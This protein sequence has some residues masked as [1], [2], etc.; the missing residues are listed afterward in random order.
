MSPAIVPFPP[1]HPALAGALAARDYSVPTPVQVAVLEAS[2]GPNDLLV[3][4]RTGSGKTVAFGLAMARTL[5]GEAERF[6]SQSRQPL[7][8]IIAPT[9][10]LAL[11]VQRELAWLYAGTDARIATCVGG[12][13]PRVE[14][15]DLGA[16]AHIVVGTPGRLRDHLERKRLDLGSLRTVVLDEAD[17]M[18]DLGF[19]EDLTFILDATPDTRQTLLFS[20]TIPRAI[21]SLA[22]R[23]QTNAV[24]IETAGGEEQHTDIEYHAVRVGAGDTEK[25]VANVLRFHEARAAL[26]F[27][28]TREGVKRMHARLLERGFSAVALSGELTQ[29]ERT[30]A[31]QALR[32]GRARVLVA[33][34]VAARGLDLPDLTLVIH[35][36]LPNDPETLLHRSGRTGRAGRKGICMLVVPASRQRKAETL[37]YAAK[38]RVRWG[39]PPA[40]DEIRERD[41]ERFLADPVFTEDATEAELAEVAAL[42]AARTSDQIALA[43]VRLNRQK[44]PATETI[45]ASTSSSRRTDRPAVNRPRSDQ[46]RPERPVFRVMP[47]S[48]TAEPQVRAPRPPRPSNRDMT[49]FRLNIGRA[50]DADPRW[51]LPLICRAGGVTKTEIGAIKIFDNETRFEIVSEVADAFADAARTAKKKEGHISRVSASAPEDEA[52][53]GAAIAAMPPRAPHVPRTKNQGRHTSLPLAERLA[54]AAAAERPRERWK[55]KKPARPASDVSSTETGGNDR[56]ASGATRPVDHAARPGKPQ[57]PPFKPGGKGKFFPKKK[58]RTAAASTG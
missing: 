55:D 35:A 40:A 19:R 49:W 43:L 54:A 32:D 11:Q 7:A 56:S 3:S 29:N 58:P 26:V 23:Y 30:H 28:A 39:A 6:D 27:C 47:D 57:R 52:V 31:L 24:R 12:M 18:L 4:A 48:E 20:A 22:R 38:L 51:L 9:R 37:L 50:Q 21:V 16:G 33:T 15:R 36:D 46:T 10:E 14:A 13:D 34:D 44:L 1:T 2:T 42:Q 17:E 45:V 53:V 5:L 25:A 8:L 41:N